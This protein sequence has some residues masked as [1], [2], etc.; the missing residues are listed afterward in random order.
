LNSSSSQIQQN[1]RS[2]DLLLVK[3]PTILIKAGVKFQQIQQNSRFQGPL[4]EENKPRL[5]QQN[6][7]ECVN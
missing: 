4:K 2:K 7:F 1:S 5:L 3:E 6:F